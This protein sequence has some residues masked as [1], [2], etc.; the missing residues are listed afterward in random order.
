MAINRRKQSRKRTPWTLRDVLPTDDGNGRSK[1]CTINEDC[2]DRA[3]ATWSHDSDPDRVRHACRR[4]QSKTFGRWPSYVKRPDTT[5]RLVRELV[6]PP[7]RRRPSAS[8]PTYR[9]SRA[10]VDGVRCARPAVAAWES[11]ATMSAR[12]RYALVCEECQRDEFGGWPAG[13]VREEI[14][15]AVEVLPPSSS[16]SSRSCDAPDCDRRAVAA[17]ASN[18]APD[19]SWYVCEEC[20]K[21]D[22]GGWPDDA[23]LPRWGRV[24]GELAAEEESCDGCGA[25]AVA[26]WSCA[27]DDEGRAFGERV[28]TVCA[29]CQRRDF[30]EWLLDANETSSTTTNVVGDDGGDDD[31]RH[32]PPSSLKR[33]ASWSEGARTTMIRDRVDRRDN[34][35]SGDARYR[36]ELL[37]LH[38]VAV[39][40]VERT[41]LLSTPEPRVENKLVRPDDPQDRGAP[42]TGGEPSSSLRSTSDDGDRRREVSVSL[43]CSSFSLRCSFAL[44]VHPSPV[45]SF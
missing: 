9:C 38:R 20:Q 45:A 32:R 42:A 15:G 13:F 43:V 4:C 1:C 36:L 16:S 10:G 8:A 30:G 14:W 2:R 33:A 24:E 27:P 18:L 17:W 41:M 6:A 11:D 35:E 5:W 12:D 7:P 26:L 22:F 44:V 37:D 31:D 23:P 34:D 19:A 3:V 28:T 29:D 25:P 21:R 40:V 39:W